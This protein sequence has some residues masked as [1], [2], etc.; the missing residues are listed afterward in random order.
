MLDLWTIDV[1][2]CVKGDDGNKDCRPNPERSGVLPGAC[3]CFCPGLREALFV[4]FDLLF[5][6]GFMRT[7]V[8]D[9]TLR[10]FVV[11]TIFLVVQIAAFWANFH[12]NFY[13]KGACLALTFLMPFELRNLPLN[14]SI[15]FEVF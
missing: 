14:S 12:G 15:A 1:P 3:T 6:D 9:P 8:D 7:R 10:A 4:L 5:V 2:D 13:G 11:G